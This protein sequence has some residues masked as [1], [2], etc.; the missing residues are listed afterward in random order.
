M[1]ICRPK[2]VVD[3]QQ[4]AEQVDVPELDRVGEGQDRQ[5]PG[6]NGGNR[7]SADQQAPLR[8]PVGNQAGEQPQHQHRRELED[9]DKPEQK[10]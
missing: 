7:L 5:R 3:A 1:V 10:R 4:E 6:Q 9:G 8:H 2:C